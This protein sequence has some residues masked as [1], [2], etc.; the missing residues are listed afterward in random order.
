MGEVQGEYVERLININIDKI[1]PLQGIVDSTKDIF[2]HYIAIGER[3]VN[4]EIKSHKRHALE[5]AILNFR[6]KS[7]GSWLNRV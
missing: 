4:D 2:V 1:R 3:T 6:L 7:W 5:T